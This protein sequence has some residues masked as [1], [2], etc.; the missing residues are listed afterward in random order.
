MGAAPL[1]GVAQ[2]RSF[3]MIVR[4]TE[5]NVAIVLE[6]EAWDLDDVVTLAD[7]ERPALHYLAAAEVEIRQVKRALTEAIRQLKDEGEYCKG[8]MATVESLGRALLALYQLRRKL[9]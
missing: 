8:A 7:D 9:S 3:S 5:R 1:G 6:E 2:E 4:D